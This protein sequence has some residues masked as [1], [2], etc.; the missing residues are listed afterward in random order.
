MSNA[1]VRRSTGF[2]HDIIGRLGNSLFNPET[3]ENVY[4]LA[5]LRGAGIRLPNSNGSVQLVP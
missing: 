4:Q 5:R 3:T 1:A 2:D